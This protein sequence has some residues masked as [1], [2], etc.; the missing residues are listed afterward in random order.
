MLGEFGLRVDQVLSWVTLLKEDV[1]ECILAFLYGKFY[2]ETKNFHATHSVVAG[3]Y[4]AQSIL[5][6]PGHSHKNWVVSI[7]HIMQMNVVMMIEIFP[8]KQLTLKG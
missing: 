4:K 6:K 7:Y 8:L 2:F 3:P 1:H 5:V